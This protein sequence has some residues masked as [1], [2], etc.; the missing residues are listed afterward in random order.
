M[1]KF[2]KIDVRNGIKRAC[3]TSFLHVRKE[4]V[5]EFLPFWVVVQFIKLK[6]KIVNKLIILKSFWN[7]LYINLFVDIKLL[8]VLLD[9][10]LFVYIIHLT[11]IMAVKFRNVCD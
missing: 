11:N 9:K 3:P 6:V 7:R 4:V 2:F 1:S 8:V 10:S 5:E